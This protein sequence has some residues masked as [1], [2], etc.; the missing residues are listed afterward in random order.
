MSPSEDCG[1]VFHVH[2]NEGIMEFKPSARG[3]HYHN[4]F[5]ASSNIELMLVNT[6]RR[7]VKR[8]LLGKHGAFKV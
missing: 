3:L 6:V 4:V 1:R 7:N 2:D 5:D 8:Y